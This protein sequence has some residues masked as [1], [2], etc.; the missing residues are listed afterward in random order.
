MLEIADPRIALRR[1]GGDLGAA[2]GRAVV[3]E[4][5]LPARVAL[6]EHAFDRL[7]QEVLRVQERRDHRYER[8]SHHLTARTPMITS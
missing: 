2:V 3:D 4:Q 8:R 7:L 5:Q 6:G 1:P